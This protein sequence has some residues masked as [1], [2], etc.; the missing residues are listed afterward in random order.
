MVV[1]GYVH[2]RNTAATQ[3]RFRFTAKK[4]LFGCKIGPNDSIHG[5]TFNLHSVRPS[6]PNLDLSLSCTKAQAQIWLNYV[7]T[8]AYIGQRSS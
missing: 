1:A 4:T 2:T 3:G 6:S 5:G 7:F 8:R